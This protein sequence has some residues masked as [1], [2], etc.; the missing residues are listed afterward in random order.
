MIKSI[1]AKGSAEI[2]SAF[3]PESLMSCN[4]ILFICHIEWEVWIVLGKFFSQNINISL[5]ELLY[6]IEISHTSENSI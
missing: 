2:S 3:I 5:K 6:F 1:L 4:D